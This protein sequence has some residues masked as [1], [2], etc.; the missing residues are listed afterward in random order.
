M[1]R[2]RRTMTVIVAGAVGAALAVLPGASAEA[3]ADTTAPTISTITP[4]SATV[5]AGD[6][7]VATFVGHDDVAVYS[8]VATFDNGNGTTVTAMSVGGESATFNP[9]GPVTGVVPLGAPAGTYTLTYLSVGDTAGNATAYT[10]GSAVSTPSGSPALLDLSAVKVTVAQPGTA[11]V[12]APALTSFAMVSPTADRHPDEFATWSFAASDVTS[13]IT[14]VRVFITGPSAQVVNAQRGGGVLTSGKLS[15]WLPAGLELGHWIVSGVQVTDS[16][17]NMRN[18]TPDGVGAQF[19]R[20]DL[21]GPTFVGMGFDLVAGPIRADDVRVFDEQPDAVITTAA[22]RTLVAPGTAVSVSGTVRYLGHSVPYPSVAVYAETGSGATRRTVLVGVTRG[23]ASG[24]FARIVVPTKPTVYR[25]LFLGSDRG[26]AAA[27]ATLGSRVGVRVALPQ[28]LLVAARS[29]TA[30]AGHRGALVVTVSPLRSG[31]LV[32]LQRRS[33]SVW[34]NVTSARTSSRGTV[35]LTV[36]RPSTPT[37]YRWVAVYDGRYLAA[38][39]A[40]VTIRRG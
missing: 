5:L 38:T 7:L 29:V 37:V 40:S 36:A 19:G 39:S 30:R 6:P 28:R 20:P 17:G 18:Y 13:P 21:A 26:G 32:Y 14:R 25:V 23:T 27:P 9:L 11:D 31:V 34:R 16:S 1:T 8:V 2:V 12:I 10:Q 3:V 15:M 24:T 35:S 4:V 33:G 22:S